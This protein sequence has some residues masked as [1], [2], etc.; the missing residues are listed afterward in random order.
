MS[1]GVLTTRAPAAFA[2][3]KCLSTSSTVTC[4]YCETSPRARRTILAPLAPEHH[5]AVGDDDE[6]RVEDDAFLLDAQAFDETERTAEPLDSLGDVGIDEYR[7]DGCGGRR[8]ILDHG[9]LFADILHD[10]YG[11]L[12]QNQPPIDEA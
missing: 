12:W 7:D 5:G 10:L 8:L 1:C 6:L 11:S 9:R 4:T 2:R 3:S